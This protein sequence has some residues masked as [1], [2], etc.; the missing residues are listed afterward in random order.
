MRTERI[1]HFFE[2]GI[3][4]EI[5][6]LSSTELIDYAHR[7]LD[8]VLGGHLT[9]VAAAMVFAGFVKLNDMPLPLL[10]ELVECRAP[11]GWQG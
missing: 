3:L 6:E 9:K 4:D 2:S 11:E 7:E 1:L 8:D 10:E 5:G